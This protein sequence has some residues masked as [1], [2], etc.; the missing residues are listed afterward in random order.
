MKYKYL[1]KSIPF[2]TTILI[3]IFL[4]IS[5]QK[6]STRLKILIWNTPSLSLGRYLAIST[7]TGFLLSYLITNSLVKVY[8]SKHN[9]VIQYKKETPTNNINEF[10]EKDNNI[11]YDNILI[12]RDIKEPSPTINASFRVIGKTNRS[13]E[14]QDDLESYPDDISN[15]SDQTEDKDQ[16][17]NQEITP[18]QND[19]NDNSYVNW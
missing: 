10:V 9:K 17:Y 16:Y 15:F 5:N 6:E 13:I 3:I 12:E 11:D 1:Y 18:E 7:G 2:I 19:W 8:Q 14:F 4:S